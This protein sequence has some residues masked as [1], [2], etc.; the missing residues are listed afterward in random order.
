MKLAK[1]AWIAAQCVAV[2]GVVLIIGVL[3]IQSATQPDRDADEWLAPME[4]FNR[5]RGQ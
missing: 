4:E 2:G 5:E 3:L 1:W